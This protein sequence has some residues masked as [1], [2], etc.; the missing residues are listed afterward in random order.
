MG[1]LWR[2]ELGTQDQGSTTL[3]KNVGVEERKN[4]K[5][6]QGFLISRSRGS[7]KR[8]AF[9]FPIAWPEQERR[10]YY[11][12]SPGQLWLLWSLK[13]RR[14][15]RTNMLLRIFAVTFRYAFYDGIQISS[16]SLLSRSHDL[17][18][19]PTWSRVLTLSNEVS[20]WNFS[21]GHTCQHLL[22]CNAK[23]APPPYN[24]IECSNDLKQR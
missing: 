21:Y 16:P 14:K 6:K 3:A 8:P 23:I 5:R 9:V 24:R 13:Q 1:Y 17:R 10:I 22:S 19:S 2:L 7:N 15:W 4:S 18:L 12:K 11:L 20:E